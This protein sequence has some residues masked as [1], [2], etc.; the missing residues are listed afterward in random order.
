MVDIIIKH[1]IKGR[2][3]IVVSDENISIKDL[4]EL[5]KKEYNYDNDIVRI[6][7]LLT[8]GSE[9]A[10]S[11]N[12]ADY[13]IAHESTIQVIEMIDSLESYSNVTIKNKNFNGTDF[14]DVDFSSSTFENCIFDNCNLMNANLKNTNLHVISSSNII[15]EP[16]NLRD[17]YKIVEIDGVRQILSYGKIFKNMNI[18]N[19]NLTGIQLGYSKFINCKLSSLILNGTKLRGS[20]FTNTEISDCELHDN[21]DLRD[22]TINGLKSKN[23]DFKGDMDNLKNRF[24]HKIDLNKGYCC[25]PYTIIN[26]CVI[27][28]KVEIED[29]LFENV[30]FYEK[31]FISKFDLP[32]GNNGGYGEYFKQRVQIFKSTFRNCQFINCN[33]ANTDFSNGD[34]SGSV[35]DNIFVYEK[36]YSST[37]NWPLG[38]REYYLISQH[39]PEKITTFDN[40]NL[41]N[42]TFKNID[43]KNKMSFVNCNLDL[44]KM[45]NLKTISFAD[46]VHSNAGHIHYENI[47]GRDPCI[48][49]RK[50][51][52]RKCDFTDS[53]LSHAN[54]SG[55]DFEK[56][57]LRNCDLNIFTKYIPS[58]GDISTIVAG[59][60]KKQIIKS[61]LGNINF[62]DSDLRGAHLPL[63]FKELNWNL[64]CAKVRFS[65]IDEIPIGK[66]PMLSEFKKQNCD[67]SSRDNFKPND[68]ITPYD[69]F[70]IIDKEN[71]E[72]MMEQ[73]YS[74]YEA[75]IN[76]KKSELDEY[77]RIYYDFD[78]KEMKLAIEILSNE[79]LKIEYDEHGFKWC[80]SAKTPYDILGV[81]YKSSFQDCIRKINQINEDFRNKTT[82]NQLE[83]EYKLLLEKQNVYREARN[84]LTN[85][86]QKITYDTEGTNWFIDENKYIDLF[87]PDLKKKTKDGAKRKSKRKKSMKRK[88]KRKKSMKKKS[89]K[90]QSSMKRKSKRKRSLTRY[91][92][93]K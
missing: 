6:K 45:T 77:K 10:E 91:L 29:V 12:I 4:I 80:D 32:H 11:K 93:E 25:F 3:V 82:L 1:S 92:N 47:N 26:G 84:V 27:G 2:K 73:K 63:Y 15:G 68:T 35:F 17:D 8:N 88:S 61:L 53:D 18:T 49:F 36:P 16:R 22:L 86:S 75:E 74:Q 56:S 21:C 37:T 41:Y 48:N 85:V 70:D 34:F 51:S 65:Y 30:D 71:Y 69:I 7:L 40:S 42:T 78:K 58:L 79:K 31:L 46:K 23:I 38:L 14:T 19:I 89:L 83:N 59:D 13:G 9:L 43:F 55:V 60:Q 52:I 66:S 87:K 44:S 33:L 57:I 20:E 72:R 24:Y 39:G 5:I 76:K 50:S 90:K 62:Y 64:E 28:P 54:L 67:F 81:K